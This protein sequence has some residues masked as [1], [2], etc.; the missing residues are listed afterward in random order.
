MTARGILQRQGM[1]GSRVR[2][3]GH[4]SED[5]DYAL[6]DDDDDCYVVVGAS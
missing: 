3:A 1:G 5:Y 6:E 2:K 4:L